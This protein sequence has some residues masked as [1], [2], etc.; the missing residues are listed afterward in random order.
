MPVHYA[1]FLSF[2]YDNYPCIFSLMMENAVL[3]ERFR[4]KYFVDCKKKCY[5]AVR[6]VSLNFFD[7]EEVFSLN[8]G[9]AD[10]CV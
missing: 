4:W 2:V 9:T 7:Y 1:V 8:V 6:L 5:F 10:L 3:L